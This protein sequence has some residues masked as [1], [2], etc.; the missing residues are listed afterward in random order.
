[1]E[2]NNCEF[3]E[4]NGRV[5]AMLTDVN[6]VCPSRIYCPT[7]AKRGVNTLYN[8][9]LDIREFRGNTCG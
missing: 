8:M 6:G 4:K 1:M 9:L 2:L 5:E 3:R 7:W